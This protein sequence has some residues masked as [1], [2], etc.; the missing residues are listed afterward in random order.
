MRVISK[1]RLRHFWE[2]NPDAEESLLSWYREAE[3]ADWSQPSE[4]KEQ[5][6]NVSFVG[7]RVVFNIKGNYYRLVVRI[8]YQY[9]VVYVRIVCSHKE[10]DSLDVKEV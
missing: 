4:I 7:N 10:Y 3:K 8:N 9:R 6:R 1:K 5:Y 2:A